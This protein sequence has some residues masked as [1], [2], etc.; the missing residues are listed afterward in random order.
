[1][2]YCCIWR[3]KCQIEQSFQIGGQW[4]TNCEIGGHLCSLGGTGIKPS[5]NKKRHASQE[6]K[7]I[8]LDAKCK[9]YIFS[10]KLLTTVIYL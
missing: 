4:R 5:N 2:S 3:T 9:Q 6:K 10:N 7:H 1:M 8:I